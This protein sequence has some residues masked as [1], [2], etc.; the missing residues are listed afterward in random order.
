MF[1]LSKKLKNIYSHFTGEK[2]LNVALRV[3]G[4]GSK[5]LVLT[6]LSKYFSTEI[7]GNYSLIISFI[8]VSIF[9]LGLDFY[10]FSIRNILT[11][12]SHLEVRNKIASL[13]VLYLVIYGVFIIVAYISFNH[14]SYLR[15][16]LFLV[17]FL[18]ITE[19]LSQ[20]IYRL[21]IGFKKVLLANI[22]LF[23]RTM[24]WAIIIFLYF[25]FKIPFELKFVFKLWLWA[26][27]ATIFYVFLLALFQNYGYL[28][29]I[30]INIGW[31]KEGMKVC[32]LFF[33]STISLKVIEY[34]NRFVVD[35]Y[36]GN[37]IAGIFT[38]YSSVSILIT[39]Y[40]NTMVISFELP[41]L[42]KFASS[43][44]VKELLLKF[45][46][47]L[48]L[49]T[50]TIT[51]VLLMIIKPLLNWQNKDEFQ[52]YLPLLI[53]MLIAVSLM[54]YSLLYHFKLYIFHKD[55]SL[56]RIMIVSG[57]VSLF[58]TI[59]FTRFFGVYGSAVA[60]VI[61]GVLLFYMRLNEAK[62]VEI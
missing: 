50:I 39:V 59:L 38:F 60:F 47:S 29:K 32:Y 4:I 37:E 23:I 14:I 15:P 30:I 36:L 45:K 2:L 9:V 44:K 13:G 18:C 62:K 56:F 61:S 5:F 27:M 42:I 6:L 55:K 25:F 41:E 16:H 19:H 17:T 21:L 35:Y 8:T 26:N 1:F 28:K 57:I 34:A 53:F 11:T 43:N 22:L 33:I 12:D 20:E 51:I 10:N 46:K 3:G 40:I 48:A 58:I 7:F 49:H 54:N 24:G 52:E 31:I